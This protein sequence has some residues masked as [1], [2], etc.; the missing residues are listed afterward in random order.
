MSSLF[1]INLGYG[2]KIISVFKFILHIQTGNLVPWWGRVAQICTDKT[3]LYF[4]MRQVLTVQY[5]A[6][7]FLR[8]IV[9]LKPQL[10]PRGICEAF[11]KSQA[12]SLIL[13][14]MIENLNPGLLPPN[15]PLFWRMIWL[16]AVAFKVMG[17]CNQNL[18]WDT[19]PSICRYVTGAFFIHKMR[20]YLEKQVSSRNASW[21][22]KR[23]A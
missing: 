11:T 1:Q 17:Y 22:L 13:G 16:Y 7:F 6:Y 9:F 21:G 4:L 8:W 10:R 20:M 5:Y 12:G 18:H 14:H 2:R 23:R 3:P 19:S 15:P